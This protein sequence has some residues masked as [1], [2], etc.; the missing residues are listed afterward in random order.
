MTQTGADPPVGEG[1]GHAP[2]KAAMFPT[3]SNSVKKFPHVKDNKD[4][5]Q[6]PAHDLSLDPTE[7]HL[8]KETNLDK[9]FSQPA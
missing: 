3:A 6:N 8:E 1:W 7:K 4:V 2:F 9:I 5:T